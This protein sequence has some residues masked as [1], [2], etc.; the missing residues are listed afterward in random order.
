MNAERVPLG[1]VL[2]QAVERIDPPVIALAPLDDDA[3]SLGEAHVVARFLVHLPEHCIVV[4]D[5]HLDGAAWLQMFR[6]AHDAS[7]SEGSSEA[8]WPVRFHDRRDRP[9]ATG[10]GVDLGEQARPQDRGIPS[11]RRTAGNIA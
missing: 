9:V 7:L 1:G 4:G 10:R 8:K 11:E 6:A 2:H 3:T 5:W